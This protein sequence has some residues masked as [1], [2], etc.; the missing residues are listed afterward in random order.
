VEADRDF[1]S[2]GI[3]PYNLA[4]DLDETKNLAT[5]ESTKVNELRC[6][7]DAWRK[8][9]GAEM[10]KPNPEYDPNKKTAKKKKK[11]DVE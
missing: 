1:R 3:E 2:H 7:L 4:D 8:E 6:E 9:V 5:N 10:M 11:K